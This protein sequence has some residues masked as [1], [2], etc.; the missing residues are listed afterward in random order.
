MDRSSALALPARRRQQAAPKGA[1]H[2]CLRHPGL[3]VR[4]GRCRQ[5]VG[6]DVGPCA[7]LLLRQN[8]ALHLRA[9][10]TR[11]GSDE[12]SSLLV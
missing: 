8:L 3:V 9:V 12:V 11:R 1:A 7:G 5:M 2:L 4:A 6:Q 10:N